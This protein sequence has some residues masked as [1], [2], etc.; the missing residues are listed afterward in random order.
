MFKFLRRIAI[1]EFIIFC[2]LHPKVLINKNKKEY[3]NKESKD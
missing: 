2:K 1:K 3:S